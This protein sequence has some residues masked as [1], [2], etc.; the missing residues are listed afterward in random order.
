MDDGKQFVYFY[1]NR[2]EPEKVREVVPA[3][4]QYWQ[5]AS[6]DGYT[7]GP[8]S[9]R[10]G[11]LITFSASSLEEATQIIQRDPFVQEGLIDQN[12]IKEWLPE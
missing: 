3:H 6:L 2:I 1:F 8:F 12:W 9:D 7:G 11:G 5:T 10:T 4:V